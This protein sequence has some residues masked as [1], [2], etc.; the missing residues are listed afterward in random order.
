MVGTWMLTVK[1]F[2]VYLKVLIK[3]WGRDRDINCLLT[4]CLEDFTSLT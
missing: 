2:F 1:F 3:H 4:A